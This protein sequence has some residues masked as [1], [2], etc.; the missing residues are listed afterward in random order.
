MIFC[1]LETVNEL[2]VTHALEERRRV[3]HEVVMYSTG[4]DDIEAPPMLPQR[5]CIHHLHN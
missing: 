2:F 4:I 3:V 1:D 5:K